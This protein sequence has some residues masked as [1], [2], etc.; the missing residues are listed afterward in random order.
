MRREGKR[1]GGGKMPYRQN[2]FVPGHIY[3][4]YNR[5]ID[6]LMIFANPGNYVYL[7]R[8]VKQLVGELSITVLA[9][10]LMPTHYHFVLRQDGEA[11]VSTFI[12]RLFQTY[13]QAFNNQEGR[14]GA[15]F[16]GRFRHVL[17]DRDEYVTH[18]CRYVHLNPVAAG[19]VA[20]PAEWLYSNY[21][22][23]IGA[24]P[25]T[26]VD[27][28]FIRQFFPSSDAYVRFVH[29]HIAPATAQRLGPYL[30]DD[31]TDLPESSE[32]FPKGPR[33]AGR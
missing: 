19:L 6:G 25:G 9:Y 7:L 32:L 23:W 21:Q 20:D 28:A 2:V 33:G 12:Q 29:G 4:I 18:L 8:K 10:C 14:K 1:R 17:V 22:E 16:E 30:L 31:D 15:L 24:R 13:T 5:G 27:H 26:L 11:A 3:H